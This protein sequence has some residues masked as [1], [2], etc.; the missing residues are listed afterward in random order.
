MKPKHQRPHLNHIAITQGERRLETVE[1]FAVEHYRI[2]SGKVHHPPLIPVEDHARVCATNGWFKQLNMTVC[3]PVL[4]PKSDD[5]FR[6]IFRAHESHFV[7]R[8]WAADDL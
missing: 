6:T 7:P 3:G 4:A 8:I 2:C 5:G 1:P